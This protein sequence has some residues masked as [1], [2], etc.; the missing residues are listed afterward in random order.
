MAT[1]AQV[2][3]IRAVGREAGM[4]YEQILD[5]AE[6]VTGR[7]VTSLEEMSTSEASELID[8]I[9]EELGGTPA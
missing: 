7:S 8:K 6:E 9:E 2:G 5:H 1:S 3:K 4:T